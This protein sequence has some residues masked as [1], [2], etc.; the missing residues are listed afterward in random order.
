MVDPLK[1]II[2]DV[3]LKMTAKLD[4]AVGKIPKNTLIPSPTIKKYLAGIVKLL[5]ISAQSVV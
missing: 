3:K 1:N 4:Y 2:D 5:L